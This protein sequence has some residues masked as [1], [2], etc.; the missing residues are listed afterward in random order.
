MLAN[1]LGLPLRQAS[2]LFAAM[3][4]HEALVALHAS[5][6]M[7]AVALTKIGNDLR[8]MGSGPMRTLLAHPG[9]PA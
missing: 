3:A 6:K 4:G 8:L 2:N 1:R 9:Q 7:L 5:L